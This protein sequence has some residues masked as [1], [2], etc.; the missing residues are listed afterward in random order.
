MQLDKSLQK[1]RLLEVPK[2]GWRKYGMHERSNVVLNIN[3]IDNRSQLLEVSMFDMNN[4]GETGSE[5]Q[6]TGYMVQS[7]VDEVTK[8][9]N[10]VTSIRKRSNQDQQTISKLD[11]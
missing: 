5:Q 11:T 8:L 1:F 7:H 3:N 6:V 4:K 2:R 10:K 9:N